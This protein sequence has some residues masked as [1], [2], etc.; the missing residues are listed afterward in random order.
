MS[1][2]KS[3]PMLPKP[4]PNPFAVGLGQ[5]Q[6]RNLFTRKKLE[7][8]FAM[9]RRENP[10]SDSHFEQ[11]HQ[12]VACSEVPVLAHDAGK[13]QLR[14]GERDAQFFL[15][16]ATR[17]RIWRFTRFHIQFASTRAPE[18]LVRLLCPFQEQDMVLFVEAIKQSRDLVGETHALTRVQGNRDSS[19]SE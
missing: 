3:V 4:I 12:P 18:S 16:L 9:S 10:Q 11:E 14:G 17:T 8:P 7:A 13:V 1:G 19:R 6:R 15:S 5:L 2:E